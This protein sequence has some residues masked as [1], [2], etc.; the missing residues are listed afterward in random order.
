MIYELRCCT[1]SGRPVRE[2]SYEMDLDDCLIE[3][4]VSMF[5]FRL[6]SI[7]GP[8]VIHDNAILDNPTVD[9]STWIVMTP[10]D[11]R[12]M[13]VEKAKEKNDESLYLQIEL[14]GLDTWGD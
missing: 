1:E 6:I 14:L 2:L 10:S 4:Y 11:F 5:D 13:V 8:A 7:Q 3:K 9:D 12:K